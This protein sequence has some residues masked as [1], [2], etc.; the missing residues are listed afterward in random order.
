MVTRPLRVEHPFGILFNV[1]EAVDFRATDLTR[2]ISH[3]CDDRACP[4][5]DPRQNDH[6]LPA[7]PR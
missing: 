1:K 3:V 2:S 7:Q 4:A 5:D 6:A